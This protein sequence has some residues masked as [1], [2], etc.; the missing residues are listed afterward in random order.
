MSKVDFLKRAE[1]FLV[2]HDIGFVR[3]GQIGR[4]QDHKVE[5]IFKVP[6]TLDSNVAIVDPSDVRVWVSTESGSVELIHQM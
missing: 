3:P 5:V 1:E 6:E 2:N 4:R